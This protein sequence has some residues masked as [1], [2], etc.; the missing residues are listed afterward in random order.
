MS[1]L[2]PIYGYPDFEGEEIESQISLPEHFEPGTLSHQ[3]FL[4]G[5]YLQGK[6]NYMFFKSKFLL[7]TITF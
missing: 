3:T 4:M 6:V 1:T 7:S 2:L 5:Q